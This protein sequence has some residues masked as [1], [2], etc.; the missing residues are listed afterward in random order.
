MH[1]ENHILQS[2]ALLM[3]LH[4]NYIVLLIGFFWALESNSTSRKTPVTSH[5]HD[6]PAPRRIPVPS[7][8][9]GFNTDAATKSIRKISLS[10][11]EIKP[12]PVSTRL[13]NGEAGRDQSASGIGLFSHYGTADGLC[14]DALAYGKSILCDN[15]GNMWFATSGGG[16]SKFD[17][18]AFTTFTTARG[19]ADNIV[20]CISDD[21][22]GNIWFGTELGGV[23]KYDGI[24]FQTFTK[25]QGLPSNAVYSM[26][27]DT[28]GNMWF[29]TFGGGVSRYDGKTFTNYSI[30]EGLVHNLVRCIYED[31]EGNLWFGTEEGISR[32]DHSWYKNTCHTQTCKHNLKDVK[33]LELHRQE[34]KK[35]FTNYT[36][37]HGL[38]N[39]FVQ[40]VK[41][42]K[43]GNLWFATSGGGACR[44]DG[45]SF[46][47]FTTK[48]GMANNIVWSIEEDMVG[49][50]WFG[51]YGGG[52][53]KYDGKTFT[54]LTSA[55]GLSNN[56]VLSIA[57]DFHGNLW[58]GTYGGGVSKYDGQSFTTFTGTQGLTNDLVWTIAQDTEGN[59]WFGT[60]AGVSKYNKQSFTNYTIHQGL[61]N[62]I[63]RSIASDKKG[64]MW[65]GTFSGATVFDGK[66]FTTYNTKQG[67]VNDV[68]RSIL[69]DK[70]GRMW[71]G[72]DGGI[73]MF[74]GLGFTNYTVEQ[75]LENNIILGIFED[76]RGVIWFAT[77]GGGVSRF[78]GN[79]FINFT[80]RQGLSSNIVWSIA[81]DSR[82]NMWFGT[83]RG[84]SLLNKNAEQ[85][86]CNKAKDRKDK[87]LIA[88]TNFTK[89]NG[90]PDDYINAVRFDLQDNL[91][92]GLNSGLF[93]IS[94]FE[95]EKIWNQNLKARPEANYSGFVKGKT[96]NQFTG[97]PVKDVNAGQ[98]NGAM[99]VDRE[100]ILWV[101]HGAN[102]VT[103][104][105]L[106]AIPK[107]IRPP[108]LFIN[109]IKLN[110]E[111][112]SWY[113]TP[114]AADLHYDSTVVSQ[115][116][117]ALF[118]R[119]LT[120][121]ERKEMQKKYKH[122]SYTGISPWYPL[123]E[124]LVL[125][126]SCNNV[127]FD[128]N[129]V[130]TDRN[131]MVLYQYILEGYSNN[132]TPP[133]QQTHA[134]FGN[135]SE[136][137]YTFKVRA[138]NPEGI[139]SEPTA[140]VFTILPPWYRNWWMLGFYVMMGSLMVFT[141]VWLN[142]RRLIDRARELKIKVMEATHVILTQKEEV[143]R[144]KVEAEKQKEIAEYQRKIAE[145]QRLQ[146]QVKNR[147]MLDSIEY[148]KRIQTAILPPQ[149]LV[150]SF[151]H[152][153][154]ILYLPKDIVAGDFYWM[155]SIDDVIYFAICDCTG[156]GVPGA[157]VS[158]VCHNALNRSVNEFGEREPGKI[159]DKTRQL[160]QEN[161]AK[162]E[163]DVKDGMDASLCALNLQAMELLWSGA[164]N[165]LWIYRAGENRLE[166]TKA[167]YQPIGLGYRE[168]PFTT[169]RFS[170]NKGDIIYMF[171]DGYADQ[172]GGTANRKFTKG[173][174]RSLI[175]SIAQLPM[176]EQYD[177][178]LLHHH[179]WRGRGF[180]VD[181]ICV[182][183]VRV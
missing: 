32:F 116:E 42:D 111:K 112:I 69:C 73:S 80:T 133:A 68:V 143:E 89:S 37:K 131:R 38:S 74:D 136:G 107:Y 11:P 79:D 156:H 101:G 54:T 23:S 119:A 44:F 152:N 40:S 21:K 94:I 140:Y 137:T 28:H 123:P 70:K 47:R 36:V 13:P 25:A 117:V 110:E 167:D 176:D 126:Y 129:A 171:T 109:S 124:N 17:G 139:W 2:L 134:T 155:E 33:Q 60:Y 27:E 5:E 78:D 72:T 56:I 138:C 45:K 96:Y 172:F 92:L 97:Y 4:L 169:H 10:A 150:K 24:S 8:K 113:G 64:R 105:D 85:E 165:P 84:L 12:L 158:V 130:E 125:P 122:V 49:N 31:S 81:E 144:Q 174:F 61:P 154:F 51:T 141:L 173:K 180:Q 128:F 57:K 153:S 161:F 7:H 16:V 148:A 50:L 86:V 48:E 162:S 127:S 67:L 88:F 108:K 135:I 164:N 6:K 91:I 22:S 83:S 104:V 90:L 115:Q 147:E 181:D 120:K 52:V 103:R 3:K 146:V 183:G 149:R 99:Y 102:G 35:Y 132:W 163:Q 30:A 43:K 159:F 151:L 178:L 71:F 39:N 82:K 87:A 157:L 26:T 106:H 63:V 18:K 168:R 77:S 145:D 20:W 59:Y 15:K 58:F 29:G 62:N 175:L 53:C 114:K 166:E 177:K 34:M 76:S 121:E 66:T 19:M 93:V 1:K 160:L 100:G 14:L 118:G 55:Q 95:L 65:F 182:I 170:L 41:E 46:Q 9:E 179:T 142:S 98:S 75:G